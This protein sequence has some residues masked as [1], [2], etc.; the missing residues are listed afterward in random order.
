MQ[1]QVTYRNKPDS[2]KSCALCPLVREEKKE[3][4]GLEVAEGQLGTYTGWKGE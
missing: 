4:D 1:L 2:D 3:K